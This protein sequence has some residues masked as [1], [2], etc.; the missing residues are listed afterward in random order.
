MADELKQV[1]AILGPYRGKRLTMTAADAIK[2]V[3]DHWAVDPDAPPG[4]P[5]DP[6]TEAERQAAFTAANDWAQAQWTAAQNPPVDPPVDPPVTR[7]MTPA[8]TAGSYTTRSS[9]SRK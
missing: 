8:D 5:H 1:E 9:T 4:D 3:N 2:A 7:A 6:L